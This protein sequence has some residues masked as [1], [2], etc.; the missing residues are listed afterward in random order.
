VPMVPPFSELLMTRSAFLSRLLALVLAAWLGACAHVPPAALEPGIRVLLDTDANNELDDQHAIA[1]MLFNGQIFDVEGITVNRTSTGG[2]IDNHVAEAERIVKLSGLDGRIPVL[3]GADGS[4]EEIRPHLHRPDHD[5]AAAVDFII[6][7]AHQP[8]DRTLVLL[9]VGKLTNIALALEKDPSIA[10]R[11]K[12]LWLGSNYP[13]PGEHNQVNDEPALNYILD[14]DVEFEIAIVR[15]GKPSGTD[16]VWASLQEIRTRMPGTGPRIRQ[17]VEGRHGGQFTRFGDYSVSLF[18][19][20]PMQ[21]DPPSRPLFD[22]AAVA[23]LKNPS[24]ATALRI[25]A[26]I[27]VER[28]WVDRPGNPRHIT[29][30]ENFDREAIIQDFFHSVEN[31]VLVR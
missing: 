5:G 1:Y 9:P 27:L 16:A 10:S 21:G 26:P 13:D 31:P 30:W 3:K 29:I 4:F 6:R 20:Y 11:V 8:S 7:A 18:E 17:P 28:R 23:I 14:S 2:G 15:Y 19:N 24:W 12:V 22:M 25:P